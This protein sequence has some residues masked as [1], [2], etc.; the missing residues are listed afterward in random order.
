[1]PCIFILSIT[2]IV[3]SCL[4]NDDKAA[5]ASGNNLPKFYTRQN[6]VKK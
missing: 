2:I 3:S 4:L 6:L 5:A 1:M